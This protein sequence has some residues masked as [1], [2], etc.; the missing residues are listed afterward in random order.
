MGFKTDGF[1]DTTVEAST[2]VPELTATRYIGWS[3]ILWN[4]RILACGPNQESLDALGLAIAACS[5]QP[6]RVR[7]QLS[8]MQ[9]PAERQNQSPP[10]RMK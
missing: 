2:S 3:A 5:E 4:G 6:E 10:D 1:R 7:W 8:S 9:Y